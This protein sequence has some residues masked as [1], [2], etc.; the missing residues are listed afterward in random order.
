[1]NWEFFLILLSGLPYTIA[2]TFGALLIGALFGIP[3][4][5]MRM[6]KIWLLRTSMILLIALVRSVPPIV[7]I[8]LIFFAI[9]TALFPIEPLPAALISIGAIASV[10][11]AE[12]YRGGLAAIH[13][14]QAEA[15]VALNLS[16]WHT[17]KDVIAPQVMR[18]SVPLIATYTIGL[19]KDAAVASTIGVTDLS[20]QGRYVTEQTYEG[21]TVMGIVGL[22]YVAISLPVAWFS[23]Y[24]YNR[25]KRKAAV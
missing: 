22:L 12:I 21:L 11:M 5:M 9:G 13:P 15:A 14:G 16:K 10:N 25:L 23:R 7:W 20:Y 4:V 6:S 17:F 8:F 2:V 18:V 1:M 24:T 3:I 19:M